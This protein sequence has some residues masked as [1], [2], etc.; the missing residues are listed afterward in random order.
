MESRTR[1]LRAGWDLSGLIK[2]VCGH[3]NI[4]AGQITDKGRGNA[5][6]S[7]KS[8]ICY[9]GMKELG[10]SS[11]AI[12]LR[13]KMSQSAVSMSGKRGRTYCDAE[14]LDIDNL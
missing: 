7:A 4:D 6:S 2:A 14:S 1:H 8:V 3:F 10:L 5:L 12:A 9:L 13:L 11:S